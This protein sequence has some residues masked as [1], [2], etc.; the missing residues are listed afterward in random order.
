L[1]KFLATYND[2]VDGV[3]LTNAPQNAK[4]RSPHIQKEILHIFAIKVRDVIR[5]E[6]G[7]AKFCILIDAAC[8]ESKREKMA[9]I[10]ESDSFI[11]S[12]SKILPH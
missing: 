2:K 3:V 9:I 11:L 7:D 8:D 10:F 4:Y 6:I 5:K 1:I 12:M